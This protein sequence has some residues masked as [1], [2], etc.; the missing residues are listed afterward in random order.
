[1]KAKC[2]NPKCLYEWESNSKMVSVTCPSC[3]L[4]VGLRK[5]R[6]DTKNGKKQ[7]KTN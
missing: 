7:N 1:M 3:G 4:K 6:E 2:K 5:K